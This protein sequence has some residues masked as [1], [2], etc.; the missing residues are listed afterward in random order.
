MAETGFRFGREARARIY[1]TNALEPWIRSPKFP[2]LE[3]LAQ[4]PPQ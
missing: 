1:L 4:R 3:A 2:E